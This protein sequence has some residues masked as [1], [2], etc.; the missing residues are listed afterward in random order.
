MARK[1]GPSQV[2]GGF[3]ATLA[4]CFLNTLIVW[5]WPDSS[6]WA[7]GGVLVLVAAFLIY[8]YRASRKATPCDVKK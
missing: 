3:L 4:V 2:V 5:L 6:L 1:I 8:V 7:L